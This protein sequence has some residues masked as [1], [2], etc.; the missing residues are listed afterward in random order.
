MLAELTK[1]TGG[2]M[3][4]DDDSQAEIDKNL[5]LIEANLRTQY[6]LIYRPQELKSDGSFHQIELKT[7]PRVESVTIRSGYY[8]PMPR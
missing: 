3:F 4:Y 5:R 2:R 7:P 1:E 6:R 8:S